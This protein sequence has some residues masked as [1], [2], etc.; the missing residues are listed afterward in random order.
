MPFTFSP[1]NIF[2]RVPVEGSWF[3][4]FYQCAHGRCHQCWQWWGDRWTLPCGA[5]EV[6]ISFVMSIWVKFTPLLYLRCWSIFCCFRPQNMTEVWHQAAGFQSILDAIPELAGQMQWRDEATHHF[7]RGEDMCE[8]SRPED[9]EDNVPRYAD[10]ERC[11][12]KR[13]NRSCASWQ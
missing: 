13:Q 10:I 3:H 7:G 12:Q 6:S 11:C 9:P 2:L 1:S 5:Q 4:W 8:Q